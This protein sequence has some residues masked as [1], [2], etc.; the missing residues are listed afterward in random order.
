MT[1][2]FYR[3]RNKLAFTL[4]ELALASTLVLI[5]GLVISKEASSAT[6]NK[7]TV[8]KVQSTYNM[9][10][11]AA[12]QWQNENNCNGDIT[13]CIQ[14]ARNYGINNK[15]IFNGI[16]KNLP[17]VASN[18][19]LEAMGNHI[20][21]QDISKIDWLPEYTKSFDGNIQTNSTI[22]VSKYYDRNSKNLAFYKLKD[23]VTILVDISDYN[24]NTGVGFFDIN[25]KEGENQ[26]GVDVFPF[27]IGASID[28]NNPL[29]DIA[30]KK[31]NPYFSSSKYE[32]FDLC[33][34]KTNDCSAE[35][36]ATNQ[37]A[38]VLLWSKLPK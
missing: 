35:K 16:A 1:K 15:I 18:V 10:E 25:G 22:G 30:A 29:Y 7:I 33:N 8:E 17:V 34:I 6:K 9:I 37:T 27:S 13:L 20:S 38:Y 12:I 3:R 28:K 5:I 36:L 24:S 4:T 2:Y 11:D 19:D 31:F 14:D 21:G 32:S 26:I 23:G